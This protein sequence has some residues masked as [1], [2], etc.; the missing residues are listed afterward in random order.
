VRRQVFQSVQRIGFRRSMTRIL[1]VDDEP[2]LLEA[3]SFA[4]EYAGYEVELAGDGVQ[5]LAIIGER[6]PDLVVTDLMMPAMNGEE[7]CRRIREKPDW[8]AIPIIVHTSA[9]V[10]ADPQ[11]L[12][13]AY[14]RKPARMD[15]FLETVQK[16]LQG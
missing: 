7:L 11:K 3:W 13:D 2:E 14:I 4:L 12:W 15:A 1:L 8:A 6:V 9:R 5:A 10:A 16:L